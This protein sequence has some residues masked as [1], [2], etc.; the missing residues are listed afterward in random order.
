MAYKIRQKICSSVQKAGYYSIMVDETKD[1]SK[2]E[3]LSVVVRYIDHS[4]S[5]NY[6]ATIE[7]KVLTFFPA[8]NLNAASLFQYILTTLKQYNLNPT[9]I[10][11]QGYDGASVMSGHS[12]G[13]QHR[14]RGI[15]P[16][17]VYIHCQA[18]V[19]NLVLV[20]CAKNNLFATEFN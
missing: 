7:E 4:S 12:S 5:S 9:M 16:Y 18:H 14:I 17:A 13:L 3:Q 15:A 19:L 11:S 10:L 1:Q 8:E 6:T 2:Q 20:D